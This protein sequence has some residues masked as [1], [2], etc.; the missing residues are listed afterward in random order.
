M[1]FIN[2]IFIFSLLYFCWV[3]GAIL[4]FQRHSLTQIYTETQTCT[5]I[6]TDSYTHTDRHTQ[7]Q[8]QIHTQT[9]TQTYKE[10]DTH[11]HTQIHTLTDVRT[12]T[13]THL[14]RNVKLLMQCNVGIIQF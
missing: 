8:Y 2:L 12:G 6:G 1:D 10:R 14:F 13:Y 4:T 7:K 5:H 9:H 3:V 11:E